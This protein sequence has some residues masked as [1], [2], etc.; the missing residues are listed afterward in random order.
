MQP[1]NDNKCF[2]CL[3]GNGILIKNACMCT[4][5]YMHQSCQIK[6]LRKTQNENC[7]VCN[8][9]YKNVRCNKIVYYIP[10]CHFCVIFSTMICMLFCIYI[11]Y[12]SSY[13]VLAEHKYE[14]LICGCVS[15]ITIAIFI[16][17]CV[18]LTHSTL[19]E[20]GCDCFEKKQILCGIH[21]KSSIK[22]FVI[23]DRFSI[24]KK[25]TNEGIQDN[26]ITSCII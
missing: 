16:F 21:F 8:T 18:H 7:K 13:E 19:T 22:R 17:T 23:K 12:L 10:K 24:F 25:H 11:L 1:E 9:K 5:M 6:L 2:I 15:M 4:N 14:Y 26:L 3:D 20:L